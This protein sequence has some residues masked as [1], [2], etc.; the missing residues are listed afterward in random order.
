V[1]DG[2]HVAT[3]LLT[4]SVGVAAPSGTSVLD[5]FSGAA[6][7]LTSHVPEIAPAGASWSRWE[8]SIPN[9]SGGETGAASGVSTIAT[10][11]SDTADGMVSV[12]FR[13]G[14]SAPIAG[15]VL[16]ADDANNHLLLRYVG[17][18]STGQLELLRR[19]NGT[20]SRIRMVSVGPLSTPRRIASG[21]GCPAT[22]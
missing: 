16:R 4:W 21:R 11:A 17:T 1:S 5:T 13:S 14:S 18:W 20:Y 12:D 9:V 15:L 2:V 8:G 19:V 7:P 3:R 6:M 22:R 10:L